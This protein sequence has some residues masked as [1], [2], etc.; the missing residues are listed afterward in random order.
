MKSF[1]YTI[2]SF[3]ALN[4]LFLF[5]FIIVLI[6][7]TLS[8]INAQK[9]I[10]KTV[11]FWSKASFILIGKKLHITGLD[12]IKKDKKYI[13][14]ANHGS[15]F[16]IMAIMAFIPE[17][18]WFGKER[19]IKIPLFGTSLKAIN[20]VPMKSSDLKNTKLMISKLVENSSVKT[21]AIFPEGTRTLNGE[22][23]RFKKGFVHVLK[24]TKLDILPVTLNGFYKLK[25][26]NRYS[27][28]F[29]TKLEIIIGDV[30]NGEELATKEN[31]EIID[32]VKNILSSNYKK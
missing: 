29:S 23:S 28:D 20:Y 24:A 18:S 26:K 15:L 31:N 12:K 3:F 7:I 2:L 5:T 27:V 14:I 32:I 13:L 9:A 6:I 30:L 19:L 4:L 16:D 21:V 25:P 10:N 1:F 11:N 17:V 22:F 8:F